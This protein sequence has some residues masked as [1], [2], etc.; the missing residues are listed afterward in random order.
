MHA[1]ALNNELG[2]TYGRLRVVARAATERRPNG[3]RPASWH[4]ICECGELTVS[5]GWSLRAGKAKSCGCSAIETNAARFVD[6]T[7]NR[8]GRLTVIGPTRKPRP[9]S[10]GK[11]W[12]C[13][14]EC[15]RERVVHGGG[16]RYGSNKSCGCAAAEQ[17]A[18][19]CA[20][21]VGV[22]AMRAALRK[23]KWAAASRSIK[24][25][26]TDADAL[27]MF[28]RDCHYCGSP[29]SNLSWHPDGNG[30]FAYNGIDRVDNSCG[31]ESDN[32]VPCCKHC[33]IAKRSRS[34]G[35][36]LAWVARVHLHSNI[37]GVA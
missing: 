11:F 1:H 36:F 7:G 28:V 26:I 2:R 21:P 34:A 8:Y 10:K 27:Q 29:P 24:W 15:G 4:C 3:S 25:N 22:S 31:Y 12:L 32:V 5:S 6:E 18:A 9:G 17:V 16:L 33:N 37:N 30:S 13:R 19:R 20:L 23:T 14:C 35:E